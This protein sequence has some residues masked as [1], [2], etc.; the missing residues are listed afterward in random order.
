VVWGGSLLHSRLGKPLSQDPIGESWEVWE[1][2]P[3]ES[4]PLGGTTLR[5]VVTRFPEELLGSVPLRRWPQRFPLLTK[6]IDAHEPLSV[7]VHPN[8]EQARRIEGQAFGKTEAW[9]VIEAIGDA[10]IIHG[11]NREIDAET[12]RARLEAGTADDILRKVK[13]SPGETIFV[14]A[15]TVHAIGPGVL[16]HEVQETSDITYR[17][18]DWNRKAPGSDAPAR[19]LHLDK[20]LEVA[21][22]KPSRNAAVK[23]VEWNEGNVAVSLLLACEY[24]TVKRLRFPG[25]LTMDTAGKSFHI[26][27]VIEGSC[28]LRSDRETAHIGLGQSI[29]IPACFRA[30]QAGSTDDSTVLVEYL[31]DVLGDL[32]PEMEARGIDSGRIAAFL[33]Q[34]R[35]AG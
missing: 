13:A 5:E 23:P 26:V 29:V 32:V 30:Y 4:G 3:V 14:P 16:L 33:E 6:F 1:G 28:T 21:W 31:A 22:L 9:Y 12:F 7:Q 18:Y 17:L 19:E 25:E 8:D 15:G 35:A 27:T 20:G 2:D 11:L 34:F 10:W 24:F